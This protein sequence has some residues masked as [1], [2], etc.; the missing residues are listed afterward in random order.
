MTLREDIWDILLFCCLLSANPIPCNSTGGDSMCS[1]AYD[2]QILKLSDLFYQA[3][4]HSKYREILIKNTRSYNCLLLQ[5]HYD[6]F[7][8]IPYRTEINHNYAFL[9]TATK[10]SRSHK[11]GLDY[12]KIII[13]KNPVYLDSATIALIDKDEYIETVKN[14]DK[15][16]HSAMEFVEDNVNHHSGLS[17]LHPSE[18]RRRYQY[19][20]L[21]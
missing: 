16:S 1:V 12:T 13:I 7:I 5:T 14:I 11:S 6:Y 8:C 10:R 17:L 20:S 15:I 21:Q 2:Y 3:Y 9:F 18:Y 4:P 19:S